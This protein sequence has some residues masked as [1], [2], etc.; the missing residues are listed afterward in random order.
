MAAA[1][2]QSAKAVR[3]RRGG[4]ATRG[5]GRA[6][7]RA[8]AQPGDDFL[9]F[10]HRRR[11]R[12]ACSLTRVS[13]IGSRPTGSGWK[14]DARLREARITRSRSL[15]AAAQRQAE[16]GDCVDRD[17]ARARGL[18]GRCAGGAAARVRGEG[19]ACRPG[20]SS[21]ASGSLLEGDA[22]HQP[23]WH[24]GVVTIRRDKKAPRLWDTA[25]G[26]DALCSPAS[27]GR[28][29]APRSVPTVSSC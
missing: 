2:E 8:R 20:S 3:E 4:G 14:R 28:P 10:R 16:A 7:K 17:P 13:T 11:C 1:V 12:S 5:R 29:A 22:S 25:T 9:R 18:A 24:A 26:K 27:I 15:A 23:R 21:C 6:G 19:N